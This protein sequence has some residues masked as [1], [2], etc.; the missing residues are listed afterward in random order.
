M[1][2][3]GELHGAGLRLGGGYRGLSTS[4]AYYPRFHSGERR[5]I[6][7]GLNTEVFRIVNENALRHLPEAV[8]YSE[9]SITAGLET[10]PVTRG[11]S[12]RS[13]RRARASG[14]SRSCKTAG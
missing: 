7:T 13:A 6:V 10:P 5:G 9:S 12:R 4:N 11:R 3:R 2:V 1:G 14:G 8:S